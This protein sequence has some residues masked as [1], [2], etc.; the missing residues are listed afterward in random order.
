MQ[1]SKSSIYSLFLHQFVCIFYTTLIL[2]TAPRLP[3][4]TIKLGKNKN[5]K[6]TL[7]ESFCMIPCCIF[8]NLSITI[9]K[10]EDKR[11]IEL[12]KDKLLEVKEKLFDAFSN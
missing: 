7:A 2:K 4:E 8:S 10:K 12:D 5:L 6:H 11:G 9:A 1:Q 3:I